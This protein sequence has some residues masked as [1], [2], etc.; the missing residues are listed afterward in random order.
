MADS[1]KFAVSSSV[2]FSMVEEMV[3]F[4][5]K[6]QIQPQVAK[7]FQWSQAADAFRALAKQESFGKIVIQVQ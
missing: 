4:V 7:V 1:E 2:A 5:E 3:R 6:A